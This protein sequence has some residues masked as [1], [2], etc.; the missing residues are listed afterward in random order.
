MKTWRNLNQWEWVTIFIQN[1]LYLWISYF[2]K[3]IRFTKVSRKLILYSCGSWILNTSLLL[4]YSDKNLRHISAI[5][6]V[7]R[8]R[9]L[10][11]NKN[12][13]V[14]LFNFKRGN[15]DIC[16]Q[17]VTSFKLFPFLSFGEFLTPNVWPFIHAHRVVN[18]RWHVWSSV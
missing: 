8:M 6:Y 17:K 13:N 12:I 18:W 16:V 5:Y 3:W 7:L 9:A 2:E 11:H 1:N 15:S 14:S 10:K 4:E